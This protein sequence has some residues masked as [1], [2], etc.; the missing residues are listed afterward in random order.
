MASPAYIHGTESSEQ[1]RLA[2]LNQITNQA[3]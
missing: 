2:L 1:E 3:S